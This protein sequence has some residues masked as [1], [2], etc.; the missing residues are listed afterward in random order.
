MAGRGLAAQETAH[1]AAFVCCNRQ[2]TAGRLRLLAEAACREQSSR[3]RPPKHSPSLSSM[4]VPRARRHVASTRS[5]RGDGATPKAT[6]FPFPTRTIAPAAHPF[7]LVS[8]MLVRF[9]V[10]VVGPACFF[11]RG[12]ELQQAASPAPTALPPPPCTMD[13]ALRREGAI[14]VCSPVDC[15]ARYG[16]TRPLFDPTV[17]FCAVAAPSPTSSPVA[18]PVASATPSSNPQPAQ[19]RFRTGAQSH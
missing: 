9:V 13:E 17:R 19:V 5:K 14:L 1:E 7:V 10:F 3:V 11:A 16:T 4:T 15:L 18:A 6:P 2:E 8:L 12:R